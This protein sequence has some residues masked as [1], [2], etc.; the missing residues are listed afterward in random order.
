M[1]RPYWIKFINAYTERER[2]RERAREKEREKE[3]GRVWHRLSEELWKFQVNETN[4]GG[5]VFLVKYN[6]ICIRFLI[7]EILLW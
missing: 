4:P 3:S 6:Y 1:K 2:E 7:Y 5:R